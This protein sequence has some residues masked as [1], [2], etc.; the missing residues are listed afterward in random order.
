V[1]KAERV[2]RVGVRAA[3][4]RHPRWLGALALGAVLVAGCA[5][6]RSEPLDVPP[7]HQIVLG[8]IFL[9]GFSEQS[10]LLDFARDDGTFRRDVPV[11]AGR[12]RL[13][14]T[15]PPGRY[16]VVRLRINDMGRTFPMETWFPVGVVFE[17]G[18]T[19]AYVGTLGIERAGFGRQVR[20]EVRDEYERTVSEMRGR[21]PELPP[22]VARALMRTS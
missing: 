8:E 11:G 18:R 3:G 15:L 1:E 10:L 7:G 17:V 14:I 13:V 20:V 19:A 2:K 9:L 6:F 16:E 4:S 21:Y 5:V 22:V 12:N